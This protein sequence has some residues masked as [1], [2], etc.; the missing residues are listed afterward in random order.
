MGIK[1]SA[2]K[3]KAPKSVSKAISSATKA[4]GS[5]AKGDLKGAAG[6]VSELAQAGKDLT[7]DIGSANLRNITGAVGSIGAATGLS[8]LQDLASNVNREG[9]SGIDKYG[10]A[11]IDTTANVATGGTY[12]LA[13]QGVNA[14]AQGGIGG[15]VNP[16][17][18]KQGLMS[19][20]ASQAGL[21]P[22]MLQS[23]QQI[24]RGD[25]RGAALQQLG[26]LGG[27]SSTQ[28]NLA[29]SLASGQPIDRALASTG[30][31]VVSDQVGA[32]ADDAQNRALDAMTPR[33]LKDFGKGLQ[34]QFKGMNPADL[35]KK[36]ATAAGGEFGANLPGST[37]APESSWFQ[38]AW[39]GIKSGA[40]SAGSAIASGARSAGGA[41]ASGAGAVKDFA[42]SNP[43]LIAGGA[44]ALAA[45]GGYEASK[46]AAEEQARLAKAQAE[47]VMNTGRQFEG[48]QY[49]PNRFAKEQQFLSDLTAGQGYTAEEKQ[50]QRQGDVRAGRAAAAARLAG[51]EQDARKMGGAGTKSSLAASLAGAQNVGNMQADTNLAREASAQGR[52]ERSLQRGSQLG[53]LKTQEEAQL[54]Q[55]QA[56]FGLNKADQMSAARNSL[57][58]I[59]RNKAIAKGNLYG[60]LADTAGMVS[61][62]WAGDIQNAPKQQAPA[63]PQQSASEQFN[64]QYT[65]QKGDNLSSLAK[66]Y[67]TTVDAL[68]KANNIKDVN[69][70]AAGAALRIPQVQQA[71]KAVQ[72]VAKPVQ[73]VQK[74]VSTATNLFNA[75]KKFFG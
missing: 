65:I 48:M 57:A 73:Q 29:S 9:Q 52:M 64:Q 8:P 43:E 25:L 59:A 49:D 13:Q 10:D 34:D 3:I 17:S 5:V 44:N 36:G 30:R 4:V 16:N 39:K 63:V 68:A 27:L 2:P 12:G 75:G 22:N 67:G 1:I 18:I 53:S 56:Q 54:A 74:A 58:E 32:Y 46:S 24:A 7:K 66:R 19:Y 41:L 50:M 71:Q 21:D 26:S 31:A 35:L 47:Q 14:M 28:M 51:I 42:A 70:I 40:S 61:N 11:A 45:Y 55:N 6:S 20:G 23:A 15:L 72:N 38:D 33:Q 60:K 69:K 37:P 62:K